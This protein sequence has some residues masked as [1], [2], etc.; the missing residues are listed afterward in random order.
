MITIKPEPFSSGV[1]LRSL[2]AD[3]FC[4]P[5]ESVEIRDRFVSQGDN[6]LCIL[7]TRRGVPDCDR[8]I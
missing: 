7:G 1:T 6:D 3:N 5:G 8:R 4:N 2:A